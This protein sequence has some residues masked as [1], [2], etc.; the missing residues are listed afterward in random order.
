MAIRD[1][2]TSERAQNNQPATDT[3]RTA[4]S[5]KIELFPS[6]VIGAALHLVNT[7]NTHN[8]THSPERKHPELHL[9]DSQSRTDNTTPITIELQKPQRQANP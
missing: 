5:C 2:H 7:T 1:T 4:R 9:N 6:L 8:R 3:C